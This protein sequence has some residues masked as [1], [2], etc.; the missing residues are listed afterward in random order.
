[1]RVVPPGGGE[2]VG[3]SP[4]RRVEILSDHDALHATW[5]RYAPGRDGAD[6]H[7]HRRHTDLFYVLTGELTLR[8]GAEGREI[9]LPAGTLARMPP[10]VVHGFRNRGA[11]EVTYLNL[12]TPGEGFAQFL[13]DG[14][15]TPYD[16]WD[17]PAEGTRP[18]EDA[19]ISR[20]GQVLAD[21]PEIAVDVVDVEGPLAPDDRLTSYWVLDGP[22]TG[23]WLQAG[24]G[25][26][27]E[28]AGPARVLRVRV[29][30]G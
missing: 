2:V 15:M 8:L 30:V 7:V 9:T 13:R 14:D 29:P 1:M 20:D 5:S 3:D 11:G 23:A 28:V 16:Q 26:E 17:P 10:M 21:E 6:L 4:E 19:A 27:H 25:E 18:P 24:P 12:H 22:D